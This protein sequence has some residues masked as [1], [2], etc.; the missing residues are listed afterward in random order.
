MSTPL[1]S[2]SERLPLTPTTNDAR[3]ASPSLFGTAKTSQSKFIFRHQV[4]FHPH[5]ESSESFPSAHAS[6]YEASIINKS[7]ENVIARSNES[8]RQASSDNL[9][10]QNV[11]QNDGQPETSQAGIN[12]DPEEERRAADEFAWSNCVPAVHSP[13]RLEPITEKNSLATLQTKASG[14]SFRTQ[15]E[16]S[17]SS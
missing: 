15:S 14:T 5:L 9:N 3:D 11:G 7:I 16:C 17:R 12:V 10:R 4:P 13:H 8:I 6:I 1:R 2:S